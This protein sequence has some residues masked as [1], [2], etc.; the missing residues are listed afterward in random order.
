MIY[1]GYY[2]SF[3]GNIIIYC[4]EIGLMALEFEDQKYHIQIDGECI[5]NSDNA[6]IQQTIS[7]LDAYF[8][9][10]DLPELPNFDLIGTPFQLKVWNLLLSIE[11]GN[12]TTYGAIAKAYCQLMHCPKMSAQAVGNAIS[13]NPIIIMIPCHRVVGAN[14]AITGFSAGI[15]RKIKLLKLEK[16]KIEQL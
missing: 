12:T 15:D 9:Q 5:E 4:N 1:K 3:L 6:I 11:Y 7:W 10:L 13:H 14:G 2:H 8:S 16:E